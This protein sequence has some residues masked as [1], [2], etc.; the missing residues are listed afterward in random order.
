MQA[1]TDDALTHS[2]TVGKADLVLRPNGDGTRSGK[3]ASVTRP[4]VHEKGKSFSPRT[5]HFESSGMAPEDIQFGH[6]GRPEKS[7]AVPREARNP[8]TSKCHTSK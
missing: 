1:I 2:S 8:T 3:A 5:K 4:A 7:M 6:L